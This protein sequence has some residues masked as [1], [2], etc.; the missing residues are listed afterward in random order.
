MRRR[1]QVAQDLRQLGWPELARSARTMAVLAQPE[2]WRR[3]ALR[4]RF[5]RGHAV[6]VPNWSDAESVQQ[7][8]LLLQGEH[9]LGRFVDALL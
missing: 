5:L 1:S 2:G 7:A 9:P 6:T 4:A 8:E 3:V